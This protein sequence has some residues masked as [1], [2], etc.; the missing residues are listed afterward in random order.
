VVVPPDVELDLG[1]TGKG[2]AADRAAAAAAEAA[3]CGVLVSIGGD[4]AV[5]G[6]ARRDADGWAIRISEDHAADPDEDDGPVVSIS[7]GGLA[8]S[9]TTVRRWNRG[10]ISVHHIIDPRSGKPAAPWWRTAS[11]AASSCAEANGAS[12]AAIVLGPAAEAWLTD[13]CLPARLVHVDG[14]V[15][16]VSGWPADA[17]EPVA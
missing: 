17:V 6:P 15:R 16:T 7:S 13:R 3:G 5:A 10:E 4:I 9:S 11:V 12:T 1:A 2:M 8:T 14:T